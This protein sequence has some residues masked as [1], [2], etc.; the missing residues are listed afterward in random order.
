MK[1]RNIVKGC[2]DGNSVNTL[3]V[4]VYPDELEILNNLRTLYNEA[5]DI[6]VNPTEVKHGWIKKDGAS[7]F[8]K[9]H[10]YKDPE[11]NKIEQLFNEILKDVKAYAPKYKKISRKK[12]SKA[13]LMVISPA[14]VHIGK[15][16]SSFETGEEYN[17]Q[18][19]VKRV[20]EGV[21]GL[22]NKVNSFNVDKVLLIIGNDILH[23]DTPKR[24]TTS[25]TPQDTDGMFYD[26]F[27]TAYKL[28]VDVI[29]MLLTVADVKV[30]F[31]PSNHDYMSGWYLAQMIEAHFINSQ[32]IKFNCD[33]AH[34]KYF[35]Y[36]NNLIGSTHGD[37]AKGQDLPLLMAHE[38]KQWSE[39]KHKYIYT[40]HLH[41]KVSKDYM[42]VCVEALRSPSGTDSWHHKNGY[43]HA[44]KAIELFLHCK[45]HGQ[46]ARFTHI[47]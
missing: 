47:F 41:H 36:G 28:Y 35:T 7:L 9:N 26:N 12:Q 2:Q 42:G 20:L 27:R 24:T 45:H 25:G 34:R 32:N 29:E 6:G 17:Q 15:L 46:I 3:K 18:I 19:A 5:V 37:G 39:C 44:P 16:C 4:R 40:H 1:K 43:Q 38:A 31:N 21:E 23:T 14:D 22:I 13:H 10:N 8:L 30:Q 33:L 11:Q